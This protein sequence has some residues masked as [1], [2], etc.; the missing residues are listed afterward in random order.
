MQFLN[1]DADDGSGFP[2]AVLFVIPGFVIALVLA[3]V[4]WRFYFKPQRYD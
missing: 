3:I 1:A 2:R 4:A